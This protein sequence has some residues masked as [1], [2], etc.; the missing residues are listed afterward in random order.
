MYRVDWTREAKKDRETA[1]KNGYAA[2]V[3]KALNVVRQNPRDPNPSEHC[4][5]E[6]KGNFKGIHTRR[7]NR[8]NRF[9]YQILNNNEKDTDPETGEEYEGIVKIISMWGHFP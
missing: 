3:V 5:E 7:L 2:E 9:A 8:K 6:L 4:Y 1:I